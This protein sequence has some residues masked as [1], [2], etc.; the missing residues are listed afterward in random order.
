MN[1]INKNLKSP[2]LAFRFAEQRQ[3]IQFCV[4]NRLAS[5]RRG[6]AK[7]FFFQLAAANSF[8]TEKKKPT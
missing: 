1:L 4:Q 8:E 6:R 3:K 5:P 7:R 2:L